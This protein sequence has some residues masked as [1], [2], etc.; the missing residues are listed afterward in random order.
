MQ[1]NIE[2][3]IG[4]IDINSD[5]LQ[6]NP[7]QDRIIINQEKL[8]ELAENINN[9]GLKDP[10]S[11]AKH[12]ERDVYTIIDGERRWRAYGIN[13]NNA[14]EAGEINED[15]SFPI[16]ARIYEPKNIEEFNKLLFIGMD[17]GNE[18]REEV[19]PL[20]KGISYREK[21]RLKKL[22]GKP[23]RMFGDLKEMVSSLTGLNKIKRKL[24]PDQK[25]IFDTKY[26]GISKLIR[27]ASTTHYI[28]EQISLKNGIEDRYLLLR[29][30]QLCKEYSL[31][32]FGGGD[33]RQKDKKKHD[34]EINKYGNLT[35]DEIL[36]LNEEELI[37]YN[38]VQSTI[39]KTALVNNIYD[40]FNEMIINDLFDLDDPES[41]HNFRI[42][43][44]EKVNAAIEFAQLANND[45]TATG[46]KVYTKTGCKF[47]TTKKGCKI[48]IN[49]AKFEDNENVK[50]LVNQL[51]SVIQ[52][53]ENKLQ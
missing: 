6:L 8:L 40:D 23:V 17:N 1:K 29:L 16:D 32:Q 31:P 34:E 36:S 45:T 51:L 46:R 52:Q 35:E 41:N 28:E 33:A 18:Q 53:E 22:N 7:E 10:I 5:K 43:I 50:M 15:D 11:I 48:D 12:P 27:A 25:R 21:I 3:S 24:S 37:I 20:E 4:Q 26:K 39:K 42:A 19:T 44:D 38:K 47:Q 13:W 9:H 2:S 49:Y 30:A 14:L